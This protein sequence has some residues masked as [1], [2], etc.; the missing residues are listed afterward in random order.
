L[1]ADAIALPRSEEAVIDLVPRGSEEISH[2]ILVEIYYWDR[3]RR[4]RSMPN[5][6]DID[7][8]EIAPLLPHVF[9][10]DVERDPLRFRY[11]LIGTSI[12]ELLARDFTGRTV[13]VANYSEEHVAALLQIFG[14]V[15]DSRRPVGWKGNIFYVPGREWLQME[16]LLMPLGKDE[17]K[18]DIIFAGYAAVGPF[19][20]AVP[21]SQPPFENDRI[22]PEPIIA[23]AR[24]PTAA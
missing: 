7:P 4:G 5:R 3:K 19:K 13:D 2:P 14:A 16:S 12:V 11:R 22:I 10:V 21:P 15:V 9:M 17:G 6:A 24:D 8:T 20:A 1:I 23:A 18:V